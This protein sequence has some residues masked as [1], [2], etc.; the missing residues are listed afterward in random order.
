M[1]TLL[2]CFRREAGGPPS[3]AGKGAGRLGLRVGVMVHV[4][5]RGARAWGSGPT[6]LAGASKGG[7]AVL[8]TWD[9]GPRDQGRSPL[10]GMDG[11]GIAGKAIRAGRE[12][13]RAGATQAEGVAATPQS[14]MSL[15]RAMPT[16]AP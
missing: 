3:P 4:G 1:V 10:D 14:S 2:G 7:A 13:S 16:A 15:P 8:G 5:V 9:A 11:M 12:A 6:G